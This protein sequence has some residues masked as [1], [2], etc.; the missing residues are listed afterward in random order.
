[1][2]F[3]TA[4]ILFLSVM[5]LTKCDPGLEGD[6]KVFNETNQV[7]TAIYIPNGPNDTVFKDIQPG[8]EEIIKVL[9][10]LG[11]RKKFNCCPCVLH[12]IVIRS[13]A[14]NIKKD[15]SISANWDFP[16]KDKVHKKGRDPIKCEFHV[17][18]SD[19]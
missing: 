2:N 11:D 7:L 3:K 17:I 19:L 1:M 18:Q 15:P 6:L 14:G 9:G 13:S 12:S 5:L 16:G 8:S 4:I 10:G